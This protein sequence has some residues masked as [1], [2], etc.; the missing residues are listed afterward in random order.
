MKGAFSMT[1]KMSKNKRPSFSSGAIQALDFYGTM[2][3]NPQSPKRSEFHD[4][5]K[6]LQKDFGLVT[7]D[8]ERAIRRILPEKK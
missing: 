8:I 3:D 5:Q 1:T 4:D 2:A 6:A 7:R